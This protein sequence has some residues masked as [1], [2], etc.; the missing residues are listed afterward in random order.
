MPKFSI[1]DL[2][3]TTTIIGVGL[4]MAVYGSSQIDKDIP[5]E[6]WVVAVHGCLYTAG[7]CVAGAGV[8]YPTKR[9]GW[10]FLL[11][12]VACGVLS[13]FLM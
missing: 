6:P 9:F 13:R 12:G 1:K 10:G 11:G 4:G 3:I 8:M 2:L 5:S 7:W